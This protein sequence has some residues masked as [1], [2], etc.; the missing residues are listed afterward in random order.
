[1]PFPI[2]LSGAVTAQNVTVEQAIG[3][4]EGALGRA[5]A[6]FVRRRDHSI[7]FGGSPW[8][9]A[10]W[11][12]A[13][14]AITRGMLDVSASAEGVSVRYRVTFTRTL[15]FAT[16]AVAL[17]GWRF[18]QAPQVSAAMGL[19]WSALAWLWGMGMTFLMTRWRLRS[20]LERSLSPAKR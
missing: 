5:S 1:M 20:F 10:G 16:V 12:N 3:R 19:G 8:L 9:T 6:G 15:V 7:E 13:L 17:L 2:S 14:R 11:A 18:A 4:L